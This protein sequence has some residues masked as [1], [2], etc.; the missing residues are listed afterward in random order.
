LRALAAP[1][2]EVAKYAMTK[3]Q[4]NCFLKKDQVT[5][6]FIDQQQEKFL[7]WSEVD[8]SHMDHMGK[9]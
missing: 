8:P 1:L 3:L 7:I 6:A 9:A 4:R 5:E 2:G